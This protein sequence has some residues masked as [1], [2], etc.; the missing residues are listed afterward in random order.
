[1]TRFILPLFICL[2]LPGI[3][4][5]QQKPEPAP[6]SVHS[7]TLPQVP[8]KLKAGPGKELVNKHCTI[9]HSADY[10]PMQPGFTQEKWG[11]IVHK[12]VKVFGAPVPDEQAAQIAAY[13][14]AH[15][16]PTR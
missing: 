7:M 2:G 11:E 3:L 1:M 10:I 8:A 9:C 12:R 4:F 5:A 16:G 14:G 13:L 15:Y 6:A